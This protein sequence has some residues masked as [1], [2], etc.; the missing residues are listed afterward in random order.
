MEENKTTP[1]L[2]VVIPTYNEGLTLEQS[3]TELIQALSEMG[4]S[5]EIIVVDGNSTDMTVEIAR[6]M[7]IE[8][9]C[10]NN[11]GK[12][13]ALRNGFDIAKADIIVTFDAEGFVEEK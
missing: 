10:R 8:I 5:H 11:V 6:E 13:M 12:G 4:Y 9:I 3:I 7:G 2:S 1:E